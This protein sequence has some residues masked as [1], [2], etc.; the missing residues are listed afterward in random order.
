MATYNG[1]HTNE[2]R[3]YYVFD[4][5]QTGGPTGGTSANFIGVID[6]VDATTQAYFNAGGKTFGSTAEM[7]F[8]VGNKAYVNYARERRSS[9]TFV[10]TTGGITNVTEIFTPDPKITFGILVGGTVGSFTG[11][12]GDE[13]HFT[14][15]GGITV[16]GFLGHLDYG[17]SG[18]SGFNEN[19]D[20]N[21]VVVDLF[22]VGLSGSDLTAME[23]SGNFNAGN[24]LTNKTNNTQT[25][26]TRSGPIQYVN[27]ESYKNQVVGQVNAKLGQAGLT[28]HTIGNAG[29]SFGVFYDPTNVELISFVS[30][31]L[32]AFAQGGSGAVGS[33]RRAEKVFTM[34]AG[35][36]GTI[37]NVQSDGSDNPIYG[38]TFNAVTGG[39]IPG[40]SQFEEFAHAVLHGNAIIQNKI[41]GKVYTIKSKKS[42]RAVDDVNF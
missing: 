33:K 10:T 27:L 1:L 21:S 37:V 35:T 15:Q 6:A 39:T 3:V 26:M 31:M 40:Q 19:V 16:Q 32:P 17:G 20:T 36:S 7:Q 34:L 42:I 2:N 9:R 13:I 5:N 28:G 8:L 30:T 14:L 12:H 11:H 24:T 22:G 23:T 41:G 29:D 25:T 38:V 18:S 4:R